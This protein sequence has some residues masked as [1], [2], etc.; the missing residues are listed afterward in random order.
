MKK[1]KAEKSEKNLDF[2]KEIDSKT[3]W[4]LKLFPR[5]LG[6]ESFDFKDYKISKEN[7]EKIIKI[8][9][10]ESLLVENRFTKFYYVYNSKK[11]KILQFGKNN[12]TKEMND[13][14]L[15]LAQK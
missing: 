15:G 14:L 4:F 8:I 13:V 9:K 6:A 3:N 7:F 12:I 1:K 5:P 10:E 2:L 11:Q